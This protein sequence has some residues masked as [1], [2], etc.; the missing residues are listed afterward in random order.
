MARLGAIHAGHLGARYI[1][2]GVIQ[3]EGSHSGYRDCSRAYMDLEQYVLRLDLDDPLFEIRTPIVD[4]S[5]KETMDLAYR[6]GIL[7]FLLH[8]TI[9]CYEGIIRQ[10]CQSA[11]RPV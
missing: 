8:E 9:T 11:A 7:E 2:M 6:L 4:M 3:V 1:Y 5:K 10:G